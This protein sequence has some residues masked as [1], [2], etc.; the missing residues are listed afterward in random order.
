MIAQLVRKLFYEQEISKET[1]I[2]VGYFLTGSL[3]AKYTLSGAS[4]TEGYS[5]NGIEASYGFKQTVLTS[6]CSSSKVDGKASITIGGTTYAAKASESGT[7]FL[8]GGM[9]QMELDMVPH[10]TVTVWMMQPYGSFTDKVL[11]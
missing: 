3:D 8:G 6:K 7:G 4:A 10:S 5:M 1:F 2:D 9:K 11:S